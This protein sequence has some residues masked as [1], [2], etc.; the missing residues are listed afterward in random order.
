[1]SFISF[2]SPLFC[3]FCA[4]LFSR[5]TA[6]LFLLPHQGGTVLV[7]IFPFRTIQEL[8]IAFGVTGLAYLAF[9]LSFLYPED[10]H[11]WLAFPLGSWVF[12]FRFSRG[13]AFTT[14]G[15]VYKGRITTW[16]QIKRWEWRKIYPNRLAIIPRKTGQFT[17]EMIELDIPALRHDDVNSIMARYLPPIGPS[18]P[19]TGDLP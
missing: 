9:A 3:G 12:G 17:S 14:T 7:E 16:D 1:M 2:Y 6:R 4:I 8:L 5:D 10:A 13:I 19:A 18:H 11:I 15:V